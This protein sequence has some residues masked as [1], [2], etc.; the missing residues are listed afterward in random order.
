MFLKGYTPIKSLQSEIKLK[1]IFFYIVIHMFFVSATF[2]PAT[3]LRRQRRPAEV[4]VQS[5]AA[6][7]GQAQ[8]LG[9]PGHEAPRNQGFYFCLFPIT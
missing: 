7:Q 1:K 5:R 4:Q 6:L 3:Q 2:F 9:C 8:P